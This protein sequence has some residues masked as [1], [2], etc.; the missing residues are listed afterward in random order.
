[1]KVDFRLNIFPLNLYLD[2]R[3]DIIIDKNSDINP[4]YI[5][6]WKF[7]NNELYL[8]DFKCEKYSV[9]NI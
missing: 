1:M 7:E 2:K 9:I 6:S 3:E 8:N 4:G 5:A